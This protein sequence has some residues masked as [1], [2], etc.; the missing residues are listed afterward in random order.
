MTA[1]TPLLTPDNSNNEVEKRK[2]TLI[3]R[4]EQFITQFPVPA[5][6][7]TQSGAVMVR[8]ELIA[9]I[10]YMYRWRLDLGDQPIQRVNHLRE[11][12]SIYGMN[13]QRPAYD[14][15]PTVMAAMVLNEAQLPPEQRALT[16]PVRLEII[17]QALRTDISGHIYRLMS[18]ANPVAQDLLNFRLN[19]QG[20]SRDIVIDENS[21]PKLVSKKLR[22]NDERTGV[23]AIPGTETSQSTSDLAEKG[24]GPDSADLLKNIAYIQNDLAHLA[25]LNI[26]RAEADD[27]RIQLLEAGI[28]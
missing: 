24:Y 26:L 16:L 9:D 15:V 21:Q 22:V 18:W 27:L 3:Q 1:E 25:M 5:E 7:T 12:A 11:T 6:H 17:S 14:H 19:A 10:A 2:N 4:A 8:E 13:S 23:E 28:K 20:V